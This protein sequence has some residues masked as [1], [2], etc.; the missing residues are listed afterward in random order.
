AR[1]R[2][3]RRHGI[4]RSRARPV[5]SRSC[6]MKDSIRNKLEKLAERHEEVSALLADPAV[7]ADTDKFRELSMEYSRLDPIATRWRGYLAALAERAHAQE[8]VEGA[9]PE[10][11]ELG[12][13]ELASLD[14]RI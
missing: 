9:D 12:R 3:A 14:A 7:I 13:E 5:R 8:M 2:R 6:R 1:S 10:L 4:A 11:R